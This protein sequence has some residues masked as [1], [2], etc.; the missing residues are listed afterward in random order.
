MWSGTFINDK[1]P[2]KQKQDT[3][4]QQKTLSSNQTGGQV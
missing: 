3:T 1:K 4:E 2:K